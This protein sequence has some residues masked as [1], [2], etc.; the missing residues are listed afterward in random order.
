MMSLYLKNKALYVIIWAILK[1]DIFVKE[2]ILDFIILQA[3]ENS[4]DSINEEQVRSMVEETETNLGYELS[5]YATIDKPYNQFYDEEVLNAEFPKQKISTEILDRALKIPNTIAFRCESNFSYKELYTLTLKYAAVLKNKYHIKVGDVIVMDV[6]S[7]PD[8][9]CAFLACN[10]LGAK[11]RPID[12]IYSIDQIEKIL[13]EYQP[14]VVVCNAIN[15]NSMNK[16][17][18]QKD[19]PVSY[20]KLK[21]H[22]PFVPALKKSIINLLEDVNELQMHKGKSSSW[23]SFHDEVDSVTDTIKY[24]D[25]ASPYVENEIAAIFPTSGTTGEAK[26]VEV[27][28]ENFLS[29]VFKEYISDFDILEGDSLFNPMPTCSSFFW[30][31][32]ALAAF[33]GVTTSLSPVFDAKNSVKQI[34]EDDST[35]VLL[36]PII[37][38][39]LCECIED[40]EKDL[41]KLRNIANKIEKLLKKERISY[42]QLVQAK[43]HYISGGDLLPLELERRAISHS[44]NIHNNLGTS[45]NTGPSTNPNGARKNKIGYYEGCV[46]ISLP[47]NDMAIFKFDEESDLPAIESENYDIGLQYYEVGEICFNANNPNVFSNYF[48]NPN[49]T[50]NV[51]I[52]HSDG[53][54]WYHSGD[55]GYMDPAGHV[56]C[57][58]RKSGLIVRDGHKVWAPKIELIAK[59]IDGID[60]CSVIGVPNS[61]ENEVPVCFLV[62]ND[63]VNPQMKKTIVNEFYSQVLALLDAKHVPTYWKELEEIP[64]NLMAKAKIGELKEIY[65]ADINSEEVLEKAGKLKLIKKML[66]KRS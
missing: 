27:T 48:N 2:N 39:Q 22:L 9:I 45:E 55:L 47:G 44:L 8:A 7:T 3:K 15:Y 64:R 53:S 50:S 26:G 49:A 17:I 54:I 11:V 28:N 40:N 21:G 52:K 57:C 14:K 56:F 41:F 38:E 25:V 1:G 58:G 43:R 51:K 66:S 36:G 62:F 35:W 10:L 42:A 12:P 18:G 23:S 61:R 30:Y 5:G 20:I 13:I 65:D 63:S 33:L 46:G 31:T 29:N 4:L 32:I 6:L 59:E 16:A 34:A 60:D 37:I 24:E 19:I